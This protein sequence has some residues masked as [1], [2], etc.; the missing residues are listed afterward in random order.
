MSG[1][2][3]PVPQTW[4]AGLNG[5][6]S[7]LN[8]MCCTVGWCGW[9][10]NTLVSL[11][12]WW[13]PQRGAAEPGGTTCSI[14][15]AWINTDFLVSPYFKAPLYSWLAVVHEENNLLLNSLLRIKLALKTLR[16]G[17]QHF[18]WH[19]VCVVTWTKSSLQTV[20]T[21]IF[22]PPL[23][24]SFR[25][26]SSKASSWEGCYA[27]LRRTVLQKVYFLVNWWKIRHRTKL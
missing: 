17:L 14:V 18:M 1:L 15:P 26:S 6:Q 9:E 2:Q 19:M 8:L 23:S 13:C 27:L 21:F 22:L 11:W 3:L 20:V 10:A 12:A 5:H 7:Q 24:F 25:A 16:L 4:K